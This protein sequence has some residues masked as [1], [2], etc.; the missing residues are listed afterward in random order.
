MNPTRSKNPSK[1]VPTAEAEAWP[2]LRDI[3]ALVRAEVPY[4]SALEMS[5]LE[6]DKM[7]A[8]FAAWAI[9]PSERIGGLL[10]PPRQAK[11]PPKSS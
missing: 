1:P 5:P 8:I 2:E 10:E 7:L 11:T 3:S 4:E 9:P 6:A